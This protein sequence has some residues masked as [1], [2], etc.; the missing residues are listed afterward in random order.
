MLPCS[1]WQSSIDGFSTCSSNT[2]THSTV[3][4]TDGQGIGDNKAGAG[5]K[6]KRLAGLERVV[7]RGDQCRSVDI[8]RRL[9][10]PHGARGIGVH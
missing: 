4:P 10:C 8:A 5:I 6:L 3:R 9:W 1:G 2:S 7:K